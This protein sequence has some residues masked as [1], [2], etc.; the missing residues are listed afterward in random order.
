MVQESGQQITIGFIQQRKK[1][2]ESL[3]YREIEQG[4]ESWLQLRLGKCTASRVADVLAKTKT[5]VSASRANYMIELA[6]QRVTG[7][8]EPSY[9]NDA[10]QWGTDNEQ[11]ARTAFEVAHNVFVDQVAF[12][13]HP[14]IKDFGCSPDGVIGDSLLEL[15]CP[16]QSAVHWSYFKDGCPSKYY[17]QIQA[18]MSCTGA[19]SVWFVSFDPRMPTRSQLYIEEVLREEEFIKKLEDEVKQFLNEVE[20][21]SQLMKGE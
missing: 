18:Q 10:M 2:T 4:S 11:T 15:K 17:T 14:T 21:E 13:D 3:I 20:I 19:K 7:V 6:L 1:M 9:K 12:V 8:I 5:G 16:Y